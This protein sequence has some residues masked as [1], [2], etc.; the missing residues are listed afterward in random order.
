MPNRPFRR[1]NPGG[2]EIASTASA[3]ASDDMP[4][5]SGLAVH[6]TQFWSIADTSV[7]S[8]TLIARNP[9]IVPYRALEPLMKP[10]VLREELLKL[11]VPTP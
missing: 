7:C 1:I 5:V 9:L 4:T 3:T 6:L 11:P 10:G 2:S 8:L